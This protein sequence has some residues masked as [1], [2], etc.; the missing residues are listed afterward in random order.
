[1][2]PPNA[3]APRAL[4]VSR[5]V[6]ELQSLAQGIFHESSTA[7]VGGVEAATSS[8]LACCPA[9]DTPQAAWIIHAQGYGCGYPCRCEWC[10]NRDMGTAVAARLRRRAQPPLMVPAMKVRAALKEGD[11]ATS[12]NRT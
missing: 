11:P 12:L 5:L 7:M 2:V 6:S 3:L 10:A 8:S 9:H 1:M 4:Y